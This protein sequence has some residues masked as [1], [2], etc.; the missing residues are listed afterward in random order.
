[1][2]FR[3]YDYAVLRGVLLPVEVVRDRSTFRSHVNGS[4]VMM[5]GALLD[6]ED[7]EDITDRLRAA[8]SED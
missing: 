2:L 8:A 1:M 4:V 7:A 5:R 6:H 3:D